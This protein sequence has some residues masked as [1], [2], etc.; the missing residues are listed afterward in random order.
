LMAPPETIF[1]HWISTQHQLSNFGEFFPSS[2]FLSMSYSGRPTVDHGSSSRA[3]DSLHPPLRGF[4]C[5]PVHAY[6]GYQ[7]AVGTLLPSSMPVLP[8]IVLGLLTTSQS[9]SRSHGNHLSFGP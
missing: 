5:Y 7:L 6:V 8:D 9:Q 3:R 4:T 2:E 1:H